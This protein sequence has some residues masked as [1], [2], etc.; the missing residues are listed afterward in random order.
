MSMKKSNRKD[1]DDLLADLD[2]LGAPSTPHNPSHRA[3]S[4]GATTANPASSSAAEASSKAPQDAQSLLDDLDSLVQSRQ[5]SSSRAS[6][7][8]KPSTPAPAAPTHPAATSNLASTTA[9]SQAAV[10]A[11]DQANSEASTAA[12]PASEPAPA[13]AAATG[14]GW[15]G[16]GSSLFSQATKLA[17]QARA[18]LEKR[19][20]SQAEQARELG[21]RGWDLAK[22]VRGFVKDAGLEKWGEEVSK[23]GKRG[24]TDIINAV[25]PPIAAHEVIQVTLS[26][27]M[28]GYDGIEDVTYRVLAKVMEQVDSDNTEQQLVVNKAPGQSSASRPK[29]GQDQERDLN[30]VEGFEAAFRLATVNLDEI[31]KTHEVKPPAADAST[32]AT[33]PITTCPVFVRIQACLSALP[34]L[35]P[36]SGSGE[37]G[38]AAA[39]KVAEADDKQLF[40]IVLL[41]DPLHGLS[42]KTI[43][44]AVPTSWLEVPFE[45]NAWVEDSLVDVIS[46]A[47]SVAGQDYVQ[48]RMSGR[49]ASTKDGL[50]SS[51]LDAPAATTA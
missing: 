44:Q 23:V 26:H 36:S 21:N 32:G 48:G 37:K 3:A 33:L 25:A 5:S 1:V 14:G 45:E 18:E 31:V 9:S 20:P 13:A 12:G 47:L 35:S 50:A 34:G 43:S 46:T 19:A 6:N 15:G 38:K 49:T 16:W 30:A 27:D 29:Q 2:N 11:P 40:F 17:D 7:R 4:P 28:V 39:S 24:W 22:G 41:K 10:P 51:S 8:N 42:H